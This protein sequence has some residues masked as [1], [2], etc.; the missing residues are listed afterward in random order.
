M[1]KPWKVIQVKDAKNIPESLGISDERMEELSEILKKE[2][3]KFIIEELPISKM[4]EKISLTAE[5]ANEN[6]LLIFKFANIIERMKPEN[7]IEFLT[8]RL[9]DKKEGGSK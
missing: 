3:K 8:A 4:L 9:L 6:A 2:F 1:T 7:L 5:N